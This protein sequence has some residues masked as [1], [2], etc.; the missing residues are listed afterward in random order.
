MTPLV[1]PNV[2]RLEKRFGVGGGQQ[3]GAMLRREELVPDRPKIQG[4]A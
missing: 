2:R 4:A 3:P 1:L